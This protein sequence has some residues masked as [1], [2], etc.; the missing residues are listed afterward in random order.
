MNAFIYNINTIQYYT[1]PEL[2]K[3]LK[4]NSQM[5]EEK[6]AHILPNLIINGGGGGDLATYSTFRVCILSM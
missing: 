5:Y 4:Y 6:H 2:E 1:N 3:Y